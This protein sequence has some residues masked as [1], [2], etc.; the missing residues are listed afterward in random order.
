MDRRAF[1]AGAVGVLPSGRGDPVVDRRVFL[2]AATFGFLAR[3]L[4]ADAQPAGK[5]F[6]IGILGA[7][8]PTEPAS[9]PIFEAFLEGLRDLGYVEGKNIVI[10]GRYSEGK[11]DR[12][13]GLAAELVRLEVDVIVTGSGTPGP[14]AARRATS[15]IPIVMTIAGDPVGSGLVASLA[16]PGGNVTGLSIVVPDLLGKQ[17][18]LLKEAVPTVS[19]VAVLS[20]PTNPAVA[21]SLGAA[22]AAALSLHVQLQVLRARAVSELDGAMSAA[23]REG[24]GA[25]IV[26]GD[27]VFFGQRARIAK[28]AA[29]SHLPSMFLEREHA[30]AGGL[31]AYGPSFRDNY[32]RAATYVDRILRGAKPADLPVEQPRK[33][34]LLINLRTAKALGLTIPPAVL[35][36]ADEVIQ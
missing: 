1:L 31:M 18:Q 8:P 10:E 35:A 13:P 11:A 36:R 19:R 22:E 28:L 27:S 33:F 5:M 34:E 14:V 30:Q 17:L 32:R 20:N 12:L 4:V 21:V 2:G 7:Y 24:A 6:R 26:I 9:R 29:Q 15:T 25:L 23:T 3:P 16:R